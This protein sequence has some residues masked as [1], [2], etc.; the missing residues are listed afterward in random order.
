MS[1]NDPT[2]TAMRARRRIVD[3]HARIRETLGVDLPIE[4]WDGERLGPSNAPYVVALRDERSLR[5][6]LW[7]PSDVTAGEA[8]VYGWIDVRGDMIAASADGERLAAN[9]PDS[10]VQRLALVADILRLPRPTGQARNRSARLSGSVHSPER[11]RAAIAFHYDLPQRFYEAFLDERLVY[12]CAYFAPDDDDLDRAQRRKLDLVCRKLRLEPGQRLLDVGCGY[13]SLLIW[14]AEHYGVE[15][16][17]VT[18]SETQAEAGRKMIA[19]RGLSD[20][21]SIELRDYRDVDDRFDAVA[22]VGM[23]EHVGPDNLASY[24]AAVERLLPPGRTFLCHSIVLG[25]AERL[26]HGAEQTFVNRY[27]FPDG[28]LAPVWWLVRAMQQGGFE[29]VDVEQLRPHYARTLRHWI[30][31]LEANRDQAVTAASELDYRIWRSYMSAASH[32]FASGS[33]EIVQVLGRARGDAPPWPT[34]R[35]WMLTDE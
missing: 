14:A 33:L 3:V 5:A 19:E 21:V 28:G 12:S 23:A 34:G 8:Y 31:R 6:L 15:A 1:G 18:L 7:P 4:L 17:G 30:R 25:D 13:G 11:D 32:S 29:I 16:V 35:S 26:R 20:R 2:M 9:M 24:A 27:V 22:S 10:W